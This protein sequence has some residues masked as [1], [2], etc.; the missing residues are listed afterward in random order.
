MWTAFWE[1]F[2]LAVIM[3]FVS[4]DW[5]RNLAVFIQNLPVI[6]KP[7]ELLVLAVQQPVSKRNVQNHSYAYIVEVT[8][9]LV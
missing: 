1:D 4:V 9:L 2:E 6:L 8:V 5:L 3:R 7:C